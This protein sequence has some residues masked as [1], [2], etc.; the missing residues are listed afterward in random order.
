MGVSNLV[1]AASG[2]TS[3]V[4]SVQSGSAST[5]GTVTITS[6][7]TSKCIVTSFPTG[8][9]GTVA[10][11]GGINAMNIGLNNQSGVNA[12]STP[13]YNTNQMTYGYGG[14][15]G[16]GFAG[17]TCATT[18]GYSAGQFINI[19]QFVNNQNI[20]AA[21]GSTSAANFN[22]GS[23]NLYAAAYGAYLTNSTTLTVTGPCQWQVV[24]YN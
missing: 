3:A 21:N 10:V 1:A 6:V 7:N 18:V 4:K 11:S 15:Y 17:R 8:A 12:S 23:N 24:E 20:N 9:A 22:S 14:T 16:A 13:S 2:L 5:A 19:G